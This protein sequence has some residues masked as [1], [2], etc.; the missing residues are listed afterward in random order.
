MLKACVWCVWR[1]T[2]S[3]PCRNGIVVVVVI[4]RPYPTFNHS[5]LLISMIRI[6]WKLSV[7]FWS[8]KL[9]IDYILF[10]IYNPLTIQNDVY[11]DLWDYIL[12]F[13]FRRINTSAQENKRLLCWYG[14]FNSVKCGLFLNISINEFVKTKW[15]CQSSRRRSWPCDGSDYD[16][17]THCKSS[18]AIGIDNA[19]APGM[20]SSRK[21]ASYAKRDLLI[22]QINFQ[23][24]AIF[25][26]LYFNN[27]NREF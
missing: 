22:F 15:I 21:F 9:L 11:W 25:P 10:I 26:T 2:R 23:L 14:D 8:I 16:L 20:G 17:I 5:S 27:F 12:E 7:I 19:R 1:R 18:I 3:V 24:S 4:V 6:F 13:V